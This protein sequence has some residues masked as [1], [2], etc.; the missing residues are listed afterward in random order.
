MIAAQAWQI[1]AQGVAGIRC[2]AKPNLTKWKVSRLIKKIKLYIAM[3]YI[4]K[5]S[6]KDASFAKR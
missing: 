1:G 5:V 3:S 4:E 2:L 6:A